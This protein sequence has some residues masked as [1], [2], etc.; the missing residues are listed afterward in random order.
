[1]K[2]RKLK[3]IALH[4]TAVLTSFALVGCDFFKK[5]E[6]TAASELGIPEDDDATE[7]PAISDPTIVLPNTSITVKEENGYAYIAMLMTGVWDEE[8]SNWLKLCGTAD[9]NVQ[10]IW[11]TVDSKPKGIDVYN[12]AEESDRTLLADVVFL[13]DNSGSM[14]EEA[15]TVAESIIE[16]SKDLAAAGLDLRVGCVGYGDS[17]HAI[18]GALNMTTPELLSDYLNVGY[19]TSRTHYYGGDDASDL[20]SKAESGMYENGSYKEAG[21]VALR[22]AH[23]NYK[24]R[25][26]ANRVYVN[27]T[28][29]PNQPVGY[30]AWSVE[31]LNPENNNW[32]SN[33]GT[34]HTVFS[35]NQ[36]YYSWQDLYY[37]KPW[38]MSEY[39]GGSIAFVDSYARDWDLTVLPVTGAMQNSYLIRFTNIDQ[40]KDGQ[41]HEIK[42]TVKSVDNS[43]RA[44]KIIRY[45]FSTGET[46]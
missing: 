29:E 38:L 1:M 15:N 35:G 46:E 28:D 44:E 8:S 17:N 36:N 26:G 2:I 20:K 4:A 10:N 45:N 6:P 43:V 32:K 18:D 25:G 24:F 21:M 3:S 37:E 27:F 41:L 34:I 33:Y 7:A 16:W 14:D 42:I 12:V 22:F 9:K 31:Y 39:T 5:D 11:V 19:G 30:S 40:L 13:V 23:D